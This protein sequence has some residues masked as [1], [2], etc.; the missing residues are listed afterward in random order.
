[1]ELAAL[2]YKSKSKNACRYIAK[3]T[4]FVKEMIL[5]YPSHHH[6]HHHHHH[7]LPVCP[8]KG[9][10]S[11]RH[12]SPL[13][14]VDRQLCPDQPFFQHPE[15]SPSI[16]FSGVLCS[17]FLVPCAPL[18]VSIPPQS[19]FSYLIPQFHHLQFLPYFIVAHSL[20]SCYSLS[21]SAAY[22]W[23]CILIYTAW[24]ISTKIRYLLSHI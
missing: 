1:M 12:L 5:Y 6:H 8:L 21:I 19:A 2:K 3:N 24:N 18:H 9:V 7:H 16:A 10:V 17:L 15:H 23:T 11:S 22:I 20:S 4:S 14:S 13:Y